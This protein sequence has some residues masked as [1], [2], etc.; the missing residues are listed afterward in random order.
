MEILMSTEKQTGKGKVQVPTRSKYC[1]Y[2]KILP[3]VF[4][5]ILSLAKIILYI[6]CYILLYFLYPYLSMPLNKQA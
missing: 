2:L 3:Y 6:K 4:F 5:S 1:L